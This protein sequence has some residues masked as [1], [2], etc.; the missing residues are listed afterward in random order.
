MDRPFDVVVVKLL[1]NDGTITKTIAK[2]FA[3]FRKLPS[4]FLFGVCG[5][6]NQHQGVDEGDKL[7]LATII[8]PQ[9]LQI[10]S[11]SC[12]TSSTRMRDLREPMLLEIL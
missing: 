2:S 5:P 7:T 3:E 4:F 8:L 1:R 9:S 12:S 11:R 10:C 6:Y